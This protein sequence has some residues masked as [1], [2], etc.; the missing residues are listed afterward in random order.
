VDP[1]GE[2]DSFP[3]GSEEQ[4]K[5]WEKA[6]AA[7]QGVKFDDPLATMELTSKFGNRIDAKPRK[8]DGIDL[9]AQKGTE[10]YA[11]AS[12]TVENAYI[13]AP[14]EVSGDEN[15]YLKIS[16]GKGWETRYLHLDSFVVKE[17]DKVFAGQLIGYSGTRRAVS[18]HLHFEIRK[19]N[20]PKNPEVFLDKMPRE[21]ILGANVYQRVK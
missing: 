16:H 12:G 18:A 19:N 6:E 1:D 8:H 13:Q 3:D 7:R 5:Q 21:R 11:A 2:T 20:I 14:K 9:K 10:V 15:S 4:N 17:G